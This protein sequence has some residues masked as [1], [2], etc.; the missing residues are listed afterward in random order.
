[1]KVI[2]KQDHQKLGKALDTVTVKDGY[3]RNFLIPNGIALPATDGN[4]KVVQES[5]KYVAKREEKKEREARQLAKKIENVPCTMPVKIKEGEEIYGSVSS[6]EISEFL[7][8]EGFAIERSQIELDE[9]IKQL[10]VYTI[11]IK[12]YKEVSAK[13][14]VWVVKEE[15]Q[16]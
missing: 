16:Q 1:M 14:K 15:Q 8:K 9:H 7:K 3:G 6:Q 2:L 4:L 5:K 11:S 12:L 13:L 10:G